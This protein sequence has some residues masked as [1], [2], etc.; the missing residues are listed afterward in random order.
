MKNDA[1][2]RTNGAMK[3]A[4]SVVH[5]PAGIATVLTDMKVVDIALHGGNA[6]SVDTR[7]KTNPTYNQERN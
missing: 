3:L 7:T 5:N 1:T 6:Q 2:T 4:A